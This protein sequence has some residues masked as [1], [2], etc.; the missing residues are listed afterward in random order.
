MSE[1]PESVG[2][3]IRAGFEQLHASWGWFVAL[4][5][6]LIVL[7]AACIL[8]EINATLITVVVLG[9]FLLIS[10]IVTL[11]HAFQTRTWSGF[12]L[13]LLSAL[14]RLITGFMLVRYPL[15]GALGITLLL[16]VLFIVGGA[17]RAIGAG[18][19]RFPRW[20]WAVASGLISVALGITLLVQFPV[21]SL[22][23]IGLAVGI[24]LIFE[25]TSLVALGS[26][27]HGIAGRVR[28]GGAAAKA[29]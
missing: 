9:W 15:G 6:A 20:G 11:V 18:K 14:L 12:L 29:S 28:A 2:T 17:F 7:G 10:G 27:L 22:W 4:G 24:D 26:A 23:F 5:I 13:Y 1:R 21:S 19:L 8:G 16:A 25:G 3:A